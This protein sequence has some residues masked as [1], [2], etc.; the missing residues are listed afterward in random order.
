[1]ALTFNSLSGWLSANLEIVYF[2]YGLSFVVMG[3]AIWVQSKEESEFELARILWLLAWFGLVHGTNEFLD[4]WLIIKGSARALDIARSFILLVSYFLFFE[5]GRQMI[6]ICKQRYLANFNRIFGWWFTLFVVMGIFT[7]AFFSVNFWMIG[8][9]WARYL[10]G[11]PAALL[12]SSGFILYYEY[13]SKRLFPLKAKKYFFCASFFI[14]L[15]GILG[16]LIVPKAG[17]FPANWLNTE[18]FFSLTQ[19]PVQ[20]LRAICTIVITWSVCGMLGIFDREK[21]LK[22]HQEIGE[23]KLMEEKL[24]RT[25][26]ELEERIQERTQ[27]LTKANESLKNEIAVRIKIEEEKEI[28]IKEFELNQE[29]LKLQKQ[30]LE[31]SRRAIKNVAADLMQSKEILEYQNKSLE[32][33]NKELDDFTYIVSHDLKEPLRSIDAYSKFMADDYQDKLTEEGKHYL[34]RIRSNSERMKKLIEDL[35]EISRLKMKGSIIDEVESGELVNEARARLEYSIKQKNVE[36]IIKE[37]LPRIFCDRVR[38]T[39]VFLNLISN[40]IKFNDK[41]KPVI[42]VGYSDKENFYEFYVKDN[43]IGIAKEY[44]DK[45]FEIF[46]RLGRREDTEGTGAGLTIVKKIVQVHKGRVWVESTPKEGTVFYFT[47]PKEKSVILGKKMLGEILL[48]QKLVTEEDIKRALE[49]QQKM[50]RESQRDEKGGGEGND[51]N[52]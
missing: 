10:L 35:L 22:L 52:A 2:F 28:L 48:E 6:R 30:D 9:I 43:G 25:Y 29:A 38:L 7:L 4:M 15:Y 46:Q 21:L 47:I 8:S 32:E 33:I 34:E 14:L 17:F 40:A 39:E 37:N 42:E 11:F 18:S 20:V 31:D 13:E 36:V 24:E 26:E 44:F 51:R 23:H 1:M 50:E 49:A 45:I 27:A 16:G 5:F 19:I 41:Q 3:V 12:V